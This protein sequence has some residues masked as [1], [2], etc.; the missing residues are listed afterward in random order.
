MFFKS[1]LQ[2][3][4]YIVVSRG[5]KHSFEVEDFKPSE[6]GI[7]CIRGPEMAERGVATRFVMRGGG[8]G[9]ALMHEFNCE[10]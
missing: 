8:M 3:I 2:C 4:C 5:A 1:H 7:C 10:G 9:K 6:C